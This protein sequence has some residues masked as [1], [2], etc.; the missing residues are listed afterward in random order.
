MA[1]YKTEADAAATLPAAI[2][3]HLVPRK[4]VT[5]QLAAVVPIRDGC[6]TELVST[7]LLL[8]LTGEQIKY[9]VG[10]YFHVDK[11]HEEVKEAP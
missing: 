8:G 10:R 3:K 6:N 4:H 2:Q 9:V 7:L 1:Y 5:G 11:Y